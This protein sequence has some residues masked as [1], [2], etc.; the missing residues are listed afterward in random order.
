MKNLEQAFLVSRTEE[1]EKIAKD[2]DEKGTTIDVEDMLRESAHK[3]MEESRT[4]IKKTP[5][6]KK[7]YN[8]IDYRTFKLPAEREEYL[9]HVNQKDRKVIEEIKNIDNKDLI[10]H[11][12]SIVTKVI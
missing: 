11:L 12:F 9:E 7:E 10:L 4:T 8:K 6:P 1:D 5:I 2:L 3:S